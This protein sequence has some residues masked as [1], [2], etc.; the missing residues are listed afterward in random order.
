LF[1]ILSVNF[2]QSK[3]KVCLYFFYGQGC[4]HCAKVEPYLSEIEQKYDLE[5]YRFEVYNNRSNLVL[6]QKYFD[7]YNV[8]QNQRGVPVVFISDNYFVGDRPI[9]DN[10]ESK[11]KSFDKGC[12][13]PSLT[14][15][16]GMGITGEVSAIEPEKISFL[17]VTGAALV[18]SINPCAI[19]VLLILLSALLA[20]G[21]KFRA[22]KAGIAFTVSIYIVYFLFGIG[23]FSAIQVTGIS[24]LFYK[25]VGFLAII[26]GMFNIKDYFWYGGG[27]FL[28]E[29]PRS[30][31]PTLKKMLGSV[32]NPMGAFLMGFA[33]CLFEL[34]CT[35]GPY[36]FI[37]G[38]LAEKTTQA[39]AIP[40]L[41]YYNVL[42]ILPL[43]IISIVVY[44]GYSSTEKANEWKDK[45]IR[46][47]HLIAGIIMLIL[48]AIVFLGLI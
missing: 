45:N 46:K 9:S 8:P 10:L 6:L 44:F 48:G 21:E 32:T 30:W 35:G 29:I 41:L 13:C 42:F 20:S 4:P 37:L 3:D 11:I 14:K 39:L 36:I 31:R 2:I 23:L 47:L 34:P 33:V 16:T 26:I 24:A 28:M 43:I 19:A 27:G 38:L 22:F 25:F 17:I 5:I 15:K 40:I 18:D 1:S 12:S 7:A